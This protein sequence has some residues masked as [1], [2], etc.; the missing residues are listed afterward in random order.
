MHTAIFVDSSVSSP[1]IL[2]T[3][4]NIY[5]PNARAIMGYRPMTC[6]VSW[7]IFYNSIRGCPLNQNDENGNS[8]RHVDSKHEV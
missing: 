6:E 1:S 8:I 7:K 3:V 2:G 4:I 5:F